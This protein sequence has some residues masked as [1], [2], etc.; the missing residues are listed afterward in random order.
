MTFSSCSSS[1]EFLLRGFSNIFPSFYSFFFE[2]TL[3]NGNPMI[4]EGLR[5]CSKLSMNY[6]HDIY[7]IKSSGSHSS[8]CT[9]FSSDYNFQYTLLSI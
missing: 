5:K 2:I 6:F 9:E 4:L 8:S 7:S 3:F 1:S